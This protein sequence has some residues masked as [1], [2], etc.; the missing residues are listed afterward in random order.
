MSVMARK[1]KVKLTPEELAIFRRVGSVGGLTSSGNM[2][3]A[4][5][6]ARAKLAVKAREAKREERRRAEAVA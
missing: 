2:T 6:S 3:P 4:Q 5:R 1:R